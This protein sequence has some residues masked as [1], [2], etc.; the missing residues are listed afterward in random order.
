MT[1]LFFNGKIYSKRSFYEAMIVQEGKILAIGETAKIIHQVPIDEKIDLEQHLVLPGFND[2]HL[3]LYHKAKQAKIMVLNDVLSMEELISLGKKHLANNPSLSVLLGEGFNQDK[4]I[5]PIIPTKENLDLISTE[6]PIVFSRICGHIVCVNSKALALCGITKETTIP[7]GQI[8]LNEKNEPNGVLTE[9]ACGLI[10]QFYASY[11]EKTAVE[12]LQIIVNDAL[13]YGVTSVQTNDC[14]LDN[15]GYLLKVYQ[16]IT[17]KQMIRINQQITTNA[18]DQY[19]EIKKNFMENDY[20]KIGPLKFFLDG[21]LGA[22]TAALTIPYMDAPAT[23]GV[24]CIS[25]Q[26]LQELVEEANKKKVQLIFHAIGNQAIR[27]A[28]DAFAYSNEKNN[29]LRH[30]IVHLQITDEEIWNRLATYH[31]NALVQPAF[32]DYDMEIVE[33]RVG[34]KLAQ[35]SYAFKTMIETIPTS[36]GTDLPVEEINP[37]LGIYL[38]ITRRNFKNTQIYNNDQFINLHQAIEAYTIGS[39]YQEFMEDKKGLLTVGYFADFIIVDRN[40]FMVSY[41]EIKQTKVLKTYVGG[42]KV[43][44]ASLL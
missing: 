14:S 37:F 26:N 16:K 3:H 40:I 8:V 42:K 17:D 12:L 13:S 32:L 15:V 20:H 19:L 5:N 2:S 10:N 23:K 28:I 11:D 36:F 34:K 39:S 7:G 21:S 41:E 25:Y 24:L 27:D 22:R 35:T 30:G 38:A 43:Y 29:P 9:N 4:F 31:I 44:D 18:I 6:I 1:T 33:Q